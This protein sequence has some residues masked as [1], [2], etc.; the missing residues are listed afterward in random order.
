[1][2]LRV[3]IVDDEDLARERLRHLLRKESE[4]EIVAECSDGPSAVAA[5]REHHPDVVLLDIQMPQ[6]D[7]F[8]VV[9]ALAD[10]PMPAIIF[11][12]AYDQH[13]V[14]AFEAR[15]LDYLLKPTTRARLHDA[16]TRVGERTVAIPNATVPQALLDFLAERELAG[17]RLRRVT[18]REA[19]RTVV[20]PVEE[21]DWIE[22]AGNYV[23]LHVGRENHILRE[24]M[25]AL[26]AQLPP[27]LF[28]RVSR[29]AIVN[30]RRVKEL[31]ATGGGE[32]I[33]ILTNNEKI[34]VTRSPREVEE[35][36]R[37]A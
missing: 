24:T 14:R 28:L 20:V 3:I 10:G 8:E 17:S 9:R 26:E 11:V 2:K 32:H 5:V 15:A 33:I 27:D 12:T 13:A 22:A 37:F 36:L 30:L 31:R 18:V 1:M 35:R 23:L 7:G 29:S 16:L 25:S 19:E 21:I 4:V 34:P 6:M